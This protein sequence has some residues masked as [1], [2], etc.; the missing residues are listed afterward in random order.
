MR[1]PPGTLQIY[2]SRPSDRKGTVMPSALAARSTANTPEDSGALL[3]PER[4]RLLLELGEYAALGFLEGVHRPRPQ[5][6]GRAFRRFYEHT[7]I[8]IP[9]AGSLVPAEPCSHNRPVLGFHQSSGLT[10]CPEAAAE[11][12]GRFR[13]HSAL[14]YSTSGLANRFCPA[15]TAW[16]SAL[17]SS[18]PIS[19][20]AGCRCR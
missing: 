1:E 16:I 7:P 4:R 8:R 17:R 20:G 11:Q 14:P 6:W 3:P 5:A 12:A 19:H 13:P 15:R 18:A 9:D 10:L 2:E